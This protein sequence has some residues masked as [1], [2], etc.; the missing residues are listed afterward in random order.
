MFD[1]KQSIILI[2]LISA[3]VVFYSCAE[4][5]VVISDEEQGSIIS[6]S[7]ELPL[8][9][10]N[11]DE[12]YL[13]LTSDYIFDQENLRTY[14]LYIPQDSYAALN[15]DP[16]AEQYAEAMLIF[17]GDTI[18]PIGIRYKGS[19]G[20]FVGCVS[21]PDWLDPSGFKTCTK[22][23]MKVKIN[24]EDREERFFGLNKLQF[25]SMNNDP[26]QLHERL[27]YWLYGEMGV[28]APRSVHAR[29]RIN[30]VYN[31]LY[32]L[33]EQIDTRFIKQNFEDD[34]GNLYK[35]V[36]PLSMEGEP[37]PPQIYIDALKTNEEDNPTAT[38]IRTFGNDIA[39][40]NS[41]EEKLVLEQY[42]DVEELIAQIVVDRTI[43]HDDGPF[44]WYC[45]WEGCASHNFYWYEEPT[46]GTL[47]LIPWDMDN[48][49]ENIIEPANGITPIADDWGEVSNNCFPFQ[50]LDAYQWSASCDK[51]TRI[52]AGY[53]NL[54]DVKKQELINGPLS[55]ANTESVLQAWISQIEGATQ[56]ADNA[57]DDA[58]TIGQWQ[59]EV[60][61]L[62]EQLDYARTH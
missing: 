57:F 34:E 11:G 26:S 56:E 58:L 61:K 60:E 37:F 25:H 48:A 50:Y 10:P 55:L 7:D 59:A 3:S 20:A 28:K 9:T 35:E 42:M 54:F 62:R 49:F 19:I 16:A 31:G 52:W 40:A 17:E 23:S 39:N 51:L 36:W 2:L 29:L 32:A 44:H 47:V 4:D 1:L 33:T 38:L 45:S 27:A 13:N 12:Q 43:R 46:K 6:S 22:L 21:G 53:E 30:G 18:S 8:V 24:W 14:D 5:E 41:S 15:A